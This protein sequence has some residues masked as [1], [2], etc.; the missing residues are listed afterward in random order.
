MVL[1]KSMHHNLQFGSAFVN[2]GGELGLLVGYVCPNGLGAN[3][4]FPKPSNGTLK[5]QELTFAYVTYLSR[6]T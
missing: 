4:W 2:A 1:R 3:W 5:R 6:A